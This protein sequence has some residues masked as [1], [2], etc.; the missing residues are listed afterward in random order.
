LAFVLAVSLVEAAATAARADATTATV[1]G[2][3]R[4]AARSFAEGLAAFEARDYR[5]AATL[6]EAAYAAKPH[7]AAL[8]NAARSWH[9]AGEDVLSANALERYLREAPPD[10]PNRDDAN[11]TLAEVSK[12]VGRVQLR[13]VGV[14]RPQLDGAPIVGLEGT[15][16]VAP[17]E[18]VVTG[19]DGHGE[20]VKKPFT[21]R[22]GETTNVTWTPPAEGERE[23]GRERERDPDRGRDPERDRERERVEGDGSRVLSP[24][25]V[26]GGGVLVA[27]G[28]VGTILSGLDTLNKRSA[29]LSNQTQARLEAGFSSQTRTNVILGATIGVAAL[30][31]VVALLFV[32]W[33]GH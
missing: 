17:G 27:G 13:L 14:S 5:R 26:A 21:A 7:H 1:E 33:K 10:A 23:R 19:E 24:W 2:P 8:W 29:F 12:R 18:H 4:K 22:R 32:D 6:F 28:V 11:A 16:Y 31:T 30:T 25:V 15:L 3:D 9:H 20:A